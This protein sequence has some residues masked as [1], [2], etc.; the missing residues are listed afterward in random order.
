MLSLPV[1][2]NLL[3][4]ISVSWLSNNHI[5]V[6]DFTTY[7]PLYQFTESDEM[8]TQ[9]YRKRSSFGVIGSERRS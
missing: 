1:M 9:S 3:C 6:R 4:I 2:S 5:S 7:I 8:V